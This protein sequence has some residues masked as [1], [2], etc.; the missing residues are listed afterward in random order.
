[1]N[2]DLSHEYWNAEELEE[3]KVF[4][5][6]KNGYER[7]ENSPHLIEVYEQFLKLTN[8][9]SIKEYQ[10]CKGMNIISVGSGIGWLEAWW[11]KDK[12]FD[13]LSLIYYSKHRIHKISPELFKYYNVNGNVNF[14]NGS[15][16]NFTFDD[17]SVDICIMI[18]AF[19]HYDQ[20]LDML[21]R[22]KKILKPGGIV[23]I[24]GE[25]DFTNGDY[26]IRSIKHFAKY[27]LNYKGYRDLHHIFPGWQDLFPPDMVKGDI[28]YSLKEYVHFF[29]RAG[30]DQ[31]TITYDKPSRLKGMI[32]VNESL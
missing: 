12:D 4:N 8:H 1:M 16:Q 9:Q 2:K 14:I 22:L 11:L 5:V 20:P 17:H 21:R 19:H 7:L 26:F 28:H 6:I 10:D 15:M 24:A 25:P 18:Q 23:I 13:T 3:N 32:L 30:F 27:V 29:R 31:Y